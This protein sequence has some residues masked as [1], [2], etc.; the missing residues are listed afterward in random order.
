MMSSL[1]QIFGDNF[2]RIIQEK[3]VKQVDIA[4]AFKVSPNTV[5]RWVKGE[6]FP[7]SD[8]IITDLA[9]YLTVNTDDLLTSS[10]EKEL[11]ISEALLYVHNRLLGIPSDVLDKLG[12]IPKSHAVAWEDIEQNIDLCLQNIQEELAAEQA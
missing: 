4:K 3:G 12:Q 8:D 1:K 11:K 7:A 2:R 5:Q 6:S 9:K 10:R